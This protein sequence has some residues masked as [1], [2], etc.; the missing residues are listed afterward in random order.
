[1]SEAKQAAARWGAD[2]ILA[3]LKQVGDGDTLKLGLGSGSTA[4]L[5]IEELAKKLAGDTDQLQMYATSRATREV[6]EKLD[7]KVRD[8][9]G[10]PLEL[11]HTVDGADEVDCEGRL[12][13]GGG[14]ALLL[15]EIF[16]ANSRRLTILVD[17]SKLVENLGQFPLPVEIMRHGSGGVVSTLVDILELEGYP[18]DCA[19][20]RR[21]DDEPFVTDNGNWIIDLHLGSI[22]D[23]AGLRAKLRNVPGVLAVGLFER[24]ADTVVAGHCAGTVQQKEFPRSERT[25]RSEKREERE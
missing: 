2:H 17:K 8:W 1:M 12:L 14:G 22:R 25:P 7:L 19:K 3:S 9:I 11:D 23:P 4:E 24:R 10:R 21:T 18:P 15:E 20:L 5:F 16:A 13:K 6:A